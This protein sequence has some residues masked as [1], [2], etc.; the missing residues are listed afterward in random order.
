MLA[1]DDAVLP[2]PGRAPMRRALLDADDDGRFD[3]ADVAAFVD[4]LIDPNNGDPREPADPDYGRHDL[5][6]DGFTGGTSRTASFDLD[7]IDS[8]Q[9]GPSGH[10]VVFQAIAGVDVPFDET[11]ATDL[12]V[13]CYYAYSDLFEGTPAARD[14]RLPLERCV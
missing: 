1:L 14:Q 3:E 12:D 13:L 4:A 11:R 10:G 8:V 7:R 2:D 5:N 9:F 6:G